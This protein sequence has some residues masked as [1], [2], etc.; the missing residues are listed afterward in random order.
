MF[1]VTSVQCTIWQSKSRI[2]FPHCSAYYPNWQMYLLIY[3]PSAALVTGAGCTWKAR[4]PWYAGK[5]WNKTPLR[6]TWISSQPIFASTQAA[7][8]TAREA[9]K[10]HYIYLYSKSLVWYAETW[11]GI[12]FLLLELE[13]VIRGGRQLATALI[14]ILLNVLKMVT[15][16]QYSTFPRI[17]RFLL[18]LPLL[19]SQ[20]SQPSPCVPIASIPQ[21]ART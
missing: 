17:T 19:S 18:C 9:G 7:S 12:Y 14:S 15:M 8:S 3:R 10:H 16:P 2:V 20:K 13:A 11:P 6:K 4:A 21:S 1:M 5:C